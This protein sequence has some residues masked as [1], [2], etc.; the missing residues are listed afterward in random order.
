MWC[1]QLREAA[2]G[3]NH[4]AAAGF[5][6]GNDCP[7]RAARRSA[8]TRRVCVSRLTRKGP[9]CRRGRSVATGTATEGPFPHPRLLANDCTCSRYLSDRAGQQEAAPLCQSIPVRRRTHYSSAA[10][11]RCRPLP[12]VA[13]TLL[14]HS[15]LISS[16]HSTIDVSA[17]IASQS[18]RLM[19]S[20]WNTAWRSGD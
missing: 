17:M 20:V 2:L 14:P 5:T 3:A 1:H 19:A 15:F 13:D 16:P 18:M 7:E 9:T 8:W 12:V 11:A 4:Y 10:P 6:L